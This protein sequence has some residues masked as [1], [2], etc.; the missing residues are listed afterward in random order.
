MSLAFNECLKNPKQFGNSKST[1][2]MH[3]CKTFHAHV[4]Q[5]PPKILMPMW[6]S[7]PFK[8]FHAHVAP[9]ALGC[10]S[11]VSSSCASSIL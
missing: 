2:P 6:H 5:L 4:A 1:A 7:R 9:A 3:M 10:G 11:Y 8:I